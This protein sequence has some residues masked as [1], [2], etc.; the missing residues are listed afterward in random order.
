MHTWR[1]EDIRVELGLSFSLHVNS[2]IRTWVLRFAFLGGKH[3]YLLSL[4]ELHSVHPYVG[5]SAGLKFT[6]IFFYC[7]YCGYP[8]A[9]H[10]LSD[11]NIVFR[12]RTV[13]LTFPQLRIQLDCFTMRR[14]MLQCSQNVLRGSTFAALSLFS[15]HPHAHLATTSA[16][17]S[18]P[19]AHSCSVTPSPRVTQVSHGLFLCPAGLLLSFRVPLTQPFSISVSRPLAPMPC[20]CPISRLR[21]SDS[22]STHHHLT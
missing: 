9:R 12:D 18:C 4:F 10:S 8:G 14:K 19:R 6:L 13:G 11:D 21:W 1:P 15:P 17:V 2:Q 20:C 22:H 5:K 3:L 16:S 7:H